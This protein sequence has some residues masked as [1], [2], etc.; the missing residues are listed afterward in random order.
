MA[1]IAWDH[2]VELELQRSLNQALLGTGDAVDPVLKYCPIGSAHRWGTPE[3]QV[4]AAGVSRLFDDLVSADK[5]RLRHDKPHRFGRL[6]VDP[7]LEQARRLDRQVTAFSPF[8]MR[9]T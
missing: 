8:R 6:E 3:P 5:Q 4:V 9:L 1:Q 7:K 2:A